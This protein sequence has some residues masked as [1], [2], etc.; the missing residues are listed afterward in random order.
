MYKIIFLSQDNVYYY[1]NTGSHTVSTLFLSGASAGG[2]VEMSS[3]CTLASSFSEDAIHL[4]TITFT[5]ASE[6]RD[7]L[8]ADGDSE[9][10]TFMEEQGFTDDQQVEDYIR[11]DPG[12]IRMPDREFIREHDYFGSFSTQHVNLY[13]NSV[14]TPTQT[15]DQLYDTSASGEYPDPDTLDYTGYSLTL[16]LYS[17]P[18]A[19]SATLAIQPFDETVLG[20]TDANG[21]FYANGDSIP[22]CA[23]SGSRVYNFFYTGIPCYVAVSPSSPPAGSYTIT[24]SSNTYPM[25]LAL[26][27][28]LTNISN[29]VGIPIALPKLTISG[30]NITGV[31]WKWV[32]K[33]DTGTWTQLT[34]GRLASMIGKTIA[35]YGYFYF[36]IGN[37]SGTLSTSVLDTGW[38]TTDSDA[39]RSNATGQATFETSFSP[40]DVTTISISYIDISGFGYIYSWEGIIQ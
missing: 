4:G 28:D 21:T 13:A 5:P 16:E 3:D 23:G 33:D 32:M 31:E 30:S 11:F 14:F 29:T 35:G 12:A 10:A 9:G 2:T 34:R 15:L 39:M 8:P 19:G 40:G 26:E 1:Q 22:S 27:P 6:L 36:V 25:I 24:D 18:S 7:I 17:N 20:I 38:E 37:D